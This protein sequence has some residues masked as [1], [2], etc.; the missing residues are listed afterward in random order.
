MTDLEHRHT[1]VA[2][3]AK[4]TPAVTAS[5]A[6]WLDLIGDVLAVILLGVTIAYTIWQWRRDIKKYK[7]ITHKEARNE[8]EE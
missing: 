7:S 5:V 4:A 2:M 1:V 6:T 8:L 3:S